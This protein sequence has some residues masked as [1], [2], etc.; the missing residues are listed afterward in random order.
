MAKSVE[1]LVETMAGLAEEIRTAT[2][3][4][5]RK[6]LALHLREQFLG[7]PHVSRSTFNGS[8]PN[9]SIIEA[10]S[11]YPTFADNPRLALLAATF[12]ETGRVTEDFKLGI[13]FTALLVAD[14]EYEY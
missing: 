13:L 7:D 8:S 5:T 14:T 4:E 12:E 10:M 2:V 6:Y 1:D 11:T 9:N 3:A